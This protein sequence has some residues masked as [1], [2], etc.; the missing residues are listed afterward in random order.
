MTVT[1]CIAHNRKVFQLD[2]DTTCANQTLGKQLATSIT[3]AQSV[4]ENL[5][6]CSEIKKEKKS[7]VV[8][9]A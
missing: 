3:R 1:G 4:K 7:I 8:I 5:N 2:V 6:K 9:R